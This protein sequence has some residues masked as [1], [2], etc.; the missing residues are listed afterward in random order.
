MA[1]QAQRMLPRMPWHSTEAQQPEKCTL[2]VLSW[3]WRQRM[4]TDAADSCSNKQQHT[5]KMVHDASR[6][7]EVPCTI[8]CL[9][10]HTDTCSIF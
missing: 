10:L 4:A 5:G 1:A 6:W 9:N 8:K 7:T 3:T 2:C